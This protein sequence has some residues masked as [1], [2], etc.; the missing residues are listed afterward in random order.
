M[1]KEKAIKRINIVI[2]VLFLCFFLGIGGTFL[3]V[4]NDAFGWFG[5]LPSL[6]ALEKPD[7]DLSSELIS[8]D[9][10]S[11][12]KY[13]RTN[14]TPVSY[15][16]LSP[17]LVNTLIVTEDI[18][19]KEHAGIDLKGLIRAAAGFLTGQMQGGGSTI[20]MQLAENL[21]K[22]SSAN[23]GSL[24]DIPKVGMIVT[25]LKEYII[26]IKL[27]ESYTKEEIL[28]MY[29]N[30]VPF[31][32]GSYGIKVAAKTFFNKLPAQ[33]NYLESA[34]LIGSINAPTRY[35][36]VYNPENA[37]AKRTEVLYNLHKYDLLTRE[38]Y[39]SL[40]LEPFGLNYKVASHNVGLATYF[41][42]VIRGFLLSWTKEH[43]YDLFEDGLKIYTT[44]DSRLQAY[45]E[46]A[47]EE[48]MDTLQ[49]V[50]MAHLN[51]DAPWIDDDNKEIEGFIEKEIKRT[52]QYRSL[53]TR[54]G[55]NADSIEYYLNEKKKMSVFSW[56]G[57]ID[58]VFSVYDSLRYYKHFL[59]AGFMAM[60]PNTGFIKAWVGG[61]NYKHFQF[62]HVKQ[63]RRQPGSTIKP[64]VYTAA[65]DNGYSP[66]FPVVDA[67]V[68]FPRPGQEPPT[69]TPDNAN[70][71]FT[72][73][74][75]TIRQAMARSVNSST[76]Y[77]MKQ[78]GPE[79]VVQYA[80][81]LGIE[82]PLD[83]V[84]ALCLGAG[85]DVS[86]YELLGAYSTFVNKGN[87][88]KPFYISRIEDENGNIIQ[89]FVP[90]PKEVLNEE[91]AYLMLHMLRGTTEEVG[92]TGGP[93]DWSI[94]GNNEIGAKTG[95]TDNASDGWFIGV[96]HDLAAG[97]WVGGDNRSIRFKHWALGQGARTAMPIYEKFMTKVYADKSLSY[98]KGQFDRPINPVSVELDCGVYN[99]EI[100]ADS[101]ILN[102][103]EE[104]DF[105]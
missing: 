37:M 65:I 18:R 100:P 45:A 13:F 61:I 102:T 3:M 5:G 44:I 43:G 96:T 49:S 7:P 6:Q 89:Q 11:L 26:S 30:T 33:L 95:T 85:G 101:L 32:S 70:G 48:H 99:S 67:P 25:K 12:G 31:G 50:F 87:Y 66:C 34:V 40:K 57:D 41:R 90:E 55:A 54:F 72:G 29:L 51:G 38:A 42:T 58:T 47:M 68:T 22:T 15:D 93:L 88:T 63:G 84:P 104:D 28:A 64:I 60:D 8:A 56:D 74:K 59:Q 98:A 4:Q 52:V 36:P 69:W 92:G 76:A 20:T 39:D 86:L 83:P 73:N 94:K 17:E 78:L 105:F 35:N 1:T 2:W 75:M 9:G 46:Q 62:D 16:E 19:F 23:R 77:I 21:Y 91:T 103:V 53:A 82:S 81:R 10:V 27:E 14:R 24:Y 80:K 97:A 71:V 79:T